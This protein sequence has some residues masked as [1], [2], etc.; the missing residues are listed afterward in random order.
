MENSCRKKYKPSPKKWILAA[1]R[2]GFRRNSALIPANAGLFHYAGNNPVRYIDPD[3]CEDAELEKFDI[4]LV[5]FFY[6]NATSTPHNFGGK[7]LL[8]MTPDSNEQNSGMS[9]IGTDNEFEI[10]DVS[11]ERENLIDSNLNQGITIKLAPKQVDVTGIPN[12]QSNFVEEFG[13]SF[14]I[15]KQAQSIWGADSTG[16]G[17]YVSDI[18]LF[19]MSCTKDKHTGQIINIEITKAEKMQKRR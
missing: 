8:I 4:S 16:S 12:D 9:F 19:K 10:P 18:C 2:T 11:T 1:R 13:G 3:G 14:I 7:N 15:K 17:L 6:C 5:G